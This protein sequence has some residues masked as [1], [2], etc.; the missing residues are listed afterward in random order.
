MAPLPVGS[1]IVPPTV[2]IDTFS[3]V[4]DDEIITV[5]K[6]STA[7]CVLDLIPSYKKFKKLIRGKEKLDIFFNFSSSRQP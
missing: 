2:T 7:S 6:E 3:P 1:L 4:I 5:M